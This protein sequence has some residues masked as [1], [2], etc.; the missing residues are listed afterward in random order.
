MEGGVGHERWLRLHFTLKLP[1]LRLY[2]DFL[3]FIAFF[4]Y[5]SQLHLAVLK[6][7]IELQRIHEP[8][9]TS[10]LVFTKILI[11]YL[12]LEFSKNFVES[13]EIF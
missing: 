8:I 9:I 3:T 6:V 12:F 1:Q 13:W 7:C 11:I 4:L 10:R 2:A 5:Q